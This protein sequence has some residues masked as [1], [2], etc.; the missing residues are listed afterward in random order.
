MPDSNITKRVLALTLKDLMRTQPFEKV[1]VSEI[2][3]SCGVSR[4]T[5]YYHF[6]D[7]YDLVE[8]IFDTEFVSVI[9]Q[10]HVRDRYSF[11][12]AICHYFYK[13]RAF[14]A[15]LLEFTG[16]NSF[17]Q[18]FRQFLFEA[19]EPFIRFDSSEITFAASQAGLATDEARE[20]FAQFLSDAVLVSIL[21]WLTSGTPVPP[22]KFLARLQA[23]SGLLLISDQVLAQ[24]ADLSDIKE[25]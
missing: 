14:Y 3:D 1:N 6:K 10:S 9:K 2:C 16:Q 8:W 19:V 15:N 17:R 18:Y 23:V 5:F 12:P 22:E 4:K 20:F 24:E 21:R 11:V 25:E 13:E 7:K